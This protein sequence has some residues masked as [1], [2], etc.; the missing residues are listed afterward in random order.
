MTAMTATNR[1]AAVV[2]S[3]SETPAATTAGVELPLRAMS[4]KARMMPSTV[5][6][7]PTNGAMTAMVPMTPRL[8]SSELRFSIRAMESA[9]VMSARFFSP[10][11]R[12]NSRIFGSMPLFERQILIAP[13]RSSAAMRW[14]IVRSRPFESECWLAK[15]SSRSMTMATAATDRT[16]SIH[17]AGPPFWI[18]AKNPVIASTSSSKASESSRVMRTSG[19]DRQ[20]ETRRD[21]ARG[22]G[23]LLCWRSRRPFLLL[24]SRLGRA[25]LL[26]CGVDLGVEIG[27]RTRVRLGLLQERNRALVVALVRERDRRNVVRAGVVGVDCQGLVDLGLDPLPVRLVALRKHVRRLHV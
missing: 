17:I 24:A 1:P 10:R 22:A 26:E 5:P 8:R 7:R 2:I 12:P 20:G 25:Q 9:S 11:W 23:G 4:S 18:V 3:A 21:V 6:N 19:G 15:K 14:P 27:V 16:N 13:G